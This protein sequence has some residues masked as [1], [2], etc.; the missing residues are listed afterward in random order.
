MA[1]AS[2]RR[3]F[4]GPLH[5]AP[6]ARRKPPAATP[7]RPLEL[8]PAPPSARSVGRAVLKVARAESPTSSERDRVLAGV[9]A[10]LQG[11]TGA[12]R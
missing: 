12:N 3:S 9:L 10:A 11:L 1:N 5:T 4:H 6:P 8:V 7:S 2:T